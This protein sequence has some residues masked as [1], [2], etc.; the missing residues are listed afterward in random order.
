LTRRQGY[1][2]W[3]WIGL[4][5]LLAFPALLVITQIPGSPLAQV[6]EQ[7]R[8]VG[9]TTLAQYTITS[10]QVLTS[11]GLTYFTSV[12]GLVTSNGFTYTTMQTTMTTSGATT[13]TTTQ[14]T[15]T[16]QAITTS[17]TSFATTTSGTGS[18]TTTV[19]TVTHECEPWP[20]CGNEIEPGGHR[21]G[22]SGSLCWSYSLVPVWS[23][24]GFA[25]DIVNG[26]KVTRIPPNI[27]AF[28]LVV[29]I[30]GAF[31]VYSRRHVILSWF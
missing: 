18:I 23:S 10:E 20:S 29:A 21:S 15:Q 9:L 31:T 8:I 11:G 3:G 25:L 22:C 16:T 27:S 30:L 2:L 7:G 5:A 13:Y 28:M 17:S 12:T 14:V 26:D 1:D 19:T 4:I 24:G 6:I